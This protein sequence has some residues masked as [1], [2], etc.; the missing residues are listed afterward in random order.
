MDPRTT[1]SPEL[2]EVSSHSRKKA[3]PVRDVGDLAA[4]QEGIVGH[5]QL[6]DLGFGERWIQHRLISGWLRQVFRG[7][8]AVGHKRITWRGRLRAAILSC[9]PNALISHRTAAALHNLI[10]G[11]GGKIHVTVPGGGHEDRDGIVLHRVRRIAAADIAEVDGI[12]VTSVARTC[13]DQAAIVRGPVL[14]DI[15]E[16]AERSSNFDLEAM[17]AVCGRGRTGSTALKRALLLYQPIPGWTRS[18][19]ERRLFRALRKRGAPLPG[20]NLWVED[21]ECDLVWHD[22]H[23]VVEVDGD[24]WHSTTASKARDPRRD[25]KLQIAGFATFRVPENRIVYEIDGVVDDV[26]ALLRRPA[27]R[28]PARPGP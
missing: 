27:V 1:V 20:V 28:T 15:L 19:L 26:I 8:Y 17:L 7:A 22:E 14:D 11:G 24:V 13:L 25:A 23:L 16:A 2:V 18:R 10:R 9:G 4:A 3:R 21:Q 12:P 5:Q 6:L